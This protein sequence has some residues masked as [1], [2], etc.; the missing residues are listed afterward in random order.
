MVAQK[1][2]QEERMREEKL[3]KLDQKMR[4]AEMNA[5]EQRAEREARIKGGWL[6][7]QDNVVNVV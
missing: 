7:R 6:Y 5:R 3:A 1:E 2:G 4:K